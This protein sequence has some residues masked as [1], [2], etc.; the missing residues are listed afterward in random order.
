MS[1]IQIF[2]LL[3]QFSFLYTVIFG[4]CGIEIR[5]EIRPNWINRFVQEIHGR[6]DE[7]NKVKTRSWRILNV[8]LKTLDSEWQGSIRSALG[9]VL[10]FLSNEGD[11][12]ME[13][14]LELRKEVEGT[15]RILEALVTVQVLV[16]LG[17]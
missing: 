1:G 11:V 17:A 7:L 10:S 4:L 2:W 8:I 6:Y 14:R 13:N 12:G 16:Q 5:M 15:L 3:G 9:L